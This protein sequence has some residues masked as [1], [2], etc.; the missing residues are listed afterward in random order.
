[1]SEGENPAALRLR[2]IKLNRVPWFEVTLG[3][4]VGVDDVCARLA[5]RL[6]NSLFG[7]GRGSPFMG[8]AK[9]GR[10]DIALRR[11][12]TLLPSPTLVGRVTHVAGGSSMRVRLRPSVGQML[13]LSGWTLALAVVAGALV[14]QHNLSVAL[15]VAAGCALPWAFFSWVMRRNGPRLLRLL[16][17]ECA[18]AP[19]PP[20]EPTTF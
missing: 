18:A 12:A 14:V 5:T 8:H 2:D 4:P 15:G 1:M 9:N 7:A 16:E 6:D 20:E 3:S 10:F 17:E 19:L 11:D 13:W